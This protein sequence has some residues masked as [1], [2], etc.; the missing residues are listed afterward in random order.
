MRALLVAALLLT[1]AATALPLGVPPVYPGFGLPPI[2]PAHQ[3]ALLDFW[4]GEEA[5]VGA[6]CGFLRFV[7]A[8]HMCDLYDDGMIC[9][10]EWEA[11]VTA[12]LW[13]NPGGVVAT[14]SGSCDDREVASWL[15]VATYT[16][17]LECNTP[18][19]F[20]QRGTCVLVPARIDADFSG[21]FLQAPDMSLEYASGVCDNR[22]PV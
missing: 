9:H 20:V 18:D 15:A 6:Y 1:P 10:L 5:V 16:V 19:F 17:I 7:D 2:Y 14:F 3:C 11:R 21:L 8:G 12:E 22:D 13:A 4:V